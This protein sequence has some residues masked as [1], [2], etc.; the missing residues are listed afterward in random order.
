MFKS[1]FD[2]ILKDKKVNSFDEEMKKF[3]N[4][5]DDFVQAPKLTEKTEYN[6]IND[7]IAWIEQGNIIPDIRNLE[8]LLRACANAGEA[9]KAK[10]IVLKMAKICNL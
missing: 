1:F 2:V 9:S 8:N 5:L 4:C 7:V 3:R 6:P 10:Q